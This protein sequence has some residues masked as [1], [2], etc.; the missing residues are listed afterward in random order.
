MGVSGGGVQVFGAKE[1]AAKLA[2]IN[3]V[4]RIYV[5][6]YVGDAALT[7][8]TAAIDLAP[9]RTG[10]LKT[11]IHPA[12]LG[13]YDWIAYADTTTGTDPGGEGKNTYDYAGFVEFGTSRTPAQPFMRPATAIGLT[14]LRAELQ[15]LARALEKL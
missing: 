15:V 8:T 1:I 4:A 3:K 7:I 2:K 5:G 10:N 11:S 13:S 9:M 14:K 12:K 6:Y